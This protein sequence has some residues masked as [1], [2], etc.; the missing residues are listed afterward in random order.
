MPDDLR[1]LTD[2]QLAE[3]LEDVRMK[4]THDPVAPRDGD[5]VAEA[6][7]RLRQR[8]HQSGSYHDG[9]PFGCRCSSCTRYR[10]L[11]E[12]WLDRQLPQEPSHD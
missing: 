6:A 7:S 11:E 10:R 5:Y 12:R 3:R 4:L 8:Q 9:H 1:A 2:E